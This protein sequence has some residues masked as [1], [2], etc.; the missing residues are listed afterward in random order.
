MV[1]RKMVLSTIV[2]TVCA[3]LILAALSYFPRLLRFDS[4]ESDLKAIK[5][6][7]S[8]LTT[9]VAVLKSEMKGIRD[10]LTTTSVSPDPA[11]ERERLLEGIR[12]VLREELSIAPPATLPPTQTPL[13]KES[14]TIIPPRVK[15]ML[16]LNTPT[17]R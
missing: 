16:M 7:V 5:Q 12:T 8:T 6:S 1:D 17:G 13:R 2:A 14:P 15:P 9:D 11:I 10:D 4:L 3:A